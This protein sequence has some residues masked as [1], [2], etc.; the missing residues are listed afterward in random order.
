MEITLDF[1]WLEATM[2]AG[3]RMAAFV[4]IA[5][6]FSYQGFP[7]RIKA[8]LALGL[9]LA[10]SP[11]V[12]PGYQI[13]STSGFFTALVLEVLT[14]AALGFLV[15]LV[16][17]AVQTAGALIDLQSGFTMAQAFDPGQNVVGAQ[18]TKLFNMTAI[19][20]MFTSDAYQLIIA[21]LARSFTALPVGSGLTLDA[22]LLVTGVSQMFLA[23]LQIAGPLVVVLFLADV[24]LGLLTRVAPQ[25]NAFALGFPLKILITLTM[26]TFLYLGLP[27]VVS[28][29]TD[30]ALDLMGG[31][32]GG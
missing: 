13:Q 27:G 14:G 26:G 2:L 25:L 15:Y 24:G 3:V 4:V 6:P 7:M 19:A 9:A 16:F 1:A 30:R 18:Y 11:L 23:A 21:G 22:E 12:A 17:A 5:P 32:A 31:A 10:V 28:S 8:I 29:L 20:L